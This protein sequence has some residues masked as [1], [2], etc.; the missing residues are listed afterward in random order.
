[1][2]TQ[3]GPHGGSGAPAD[4]GVAHRERAA[5]RAEVMSRVSE[6][7]RV[8]GLTQR[9][10]AQ[11]LGIPQSKVSCLMNGRISMFSLDHL[12]ELL[13]ALDHDVEITIAP[14]AKAQ[15][16]AT[17]RVTVNPS[18]MLQEDRDELI[19]LSKRLTPEERLEAHLEHSQLMAEIY[20][21]GVKR[22]SRV[23]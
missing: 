2:P 13:N 8:R 15:G 10:A 5:A 17:T 3:E 23:R 12:F 9:Q 6:V 4:T 7:L 20:R 14:A 19:A 21:A 22:R 1:M 18:D 11:V 16:A